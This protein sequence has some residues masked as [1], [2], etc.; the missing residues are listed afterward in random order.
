MRIPFNSLGGGC[1][2]ALEDY[3]SARGIYHW[4][5]RYCNMPKFFHDFFAGCK[6]GV[7]PYDL[8][9]G[10]LERPYQQWRMV[11]NLIYNTLPKFIVLNIHPSV[12]TR[13]NGLVYESVIEDMQKCYYDVAVRLLSS[14]PWI[15]YMERRLYVLAVNTKRPM[16][17]E[18]PMELLKRIPQPSLPFPQFSDIKDDG[19]ILNNEL[20]LSDDDSRKVVASQVVTDDST[21]PRW[22]KDLYK[23]KG[24]HPGSPYVDVNGRYR[25]LSLRECKRIIGLSNQFD[26]MPV[27][28]SRKAYQ[29]L[30]RTSTVHIVNQIAIQL[31]SLLPNASSFRIQRKKIG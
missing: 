22:P 26:V 24:Y 13:D 11:S 2:G 23:S 30:A 15:P 8:L 17:G 12:I 31:S 1:V 5:H 9:L 4:N 10:Y 19:A 28:K 29:L 7:M 14:E 27:R 3:D 20:Y 16:Y 18:D 6:R 21:I 25:R